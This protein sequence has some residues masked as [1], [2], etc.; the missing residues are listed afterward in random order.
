MTNNPEPERDIDEALGFEYINGEW[1]PIFELTDAHKKAF[2][3]GNEVGPEGM[4]IAHSG[5]RS[6][7]K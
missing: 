3:K 2:Y 4:T 1:V 6:R 7:S 5:P